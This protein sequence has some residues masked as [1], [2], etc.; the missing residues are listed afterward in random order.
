MKRILSTICLLAAGVALADWTPVMLSLVTPVQAPSCDYG[1]KGFRLSLLYGDCTDF[2]GLD[3]S[4]LGHVDQDFTGV[5]IGAVNIVDE[6]MYGGQ[7]GVVN[8]NGNDKRLWEQRSMGAQIGLVNYS[9]SFCGLQDGVI[10]V[11]DNTFVGLQTALLGNFADDFRG[12]QTGW[13]ILSGTNSTKGE[14]N[15]CQILA[16]CNV[17][18]EMNGLQIGFINAAERMR[19]GLQIG[20]INIICNNGWFSVLPIVNGHF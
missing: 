4:V 13:Y 19:A 8:W 20:L 5:G 1:V 14:M 17:A 2:A 16:I 6:R 15:G 7:V 12:M 18:G 10:N 3:I 9:G 11:A